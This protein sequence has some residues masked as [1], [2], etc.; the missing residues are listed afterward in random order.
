[1]G[2]KEG[3]NTTPGKYM[4]TPRGIGP[5]SDPMAPI[6]PE[7]GRPAQPRG[8]PIRGSKMDTGMASQLQNETNPFANLLKQTENVFKNFGPK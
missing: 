1:M 6:M 4:N 7:Y 8:N 2:R 3:Q 5:S